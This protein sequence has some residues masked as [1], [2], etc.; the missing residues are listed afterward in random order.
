ML[1][2]LISIILYF[3]FFSDDDWEDLDIEQSINYGIDYEEI[4]PSDSE[5]HTLLSICHCICH[6]LGDNAHCRSCG[7]K[8]HIYLKKY[9]ILLNI[10]IYI[11]PFNFIK[12]IF[13]LL[14]LKNLFPSLLINYYCIQNIFIFTILIFVFYPW[15]PCKVSSE[16]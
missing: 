7:L 13:C 9:I 3:S 2:Q 4:I 14:F 5:D 15:S 10:C 16:K 12:I 6:K 11:Q 1:T 8:V